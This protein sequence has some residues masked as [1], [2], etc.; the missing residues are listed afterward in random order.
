MDELDRRIINNL[1]GGFPVSDR[2]YREAAGTLGVDETQ[3]IERLGTMLEDRRLS[4]F[5]PMFN[6]EKMGGSFCLCA[7]SVPADRFDQVTEQVNAFPQV[8]HNYER[9]HQFNMWFVLA[10]E[11]K[12]GIA[13]A[14]AGIEAATGLEVFEFPKLEEYFV[15][16]R[17]DV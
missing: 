5:G 4:R 15:G 16:L 6:V 17:F 9:D 8:A 13:E 2:P 7:M 12:E 14:V 1:Q 10:T 3:L 11:A